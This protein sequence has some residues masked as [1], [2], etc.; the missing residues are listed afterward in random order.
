MLVELCVA[1]VLSVLINVVLFIK[2]K[3]NSVNTSA[4]NKDYENL[5]KEKNDLLEERGKLKGILE[6]KDIN[7]NQINEI[8]SKT[9]VYF[10]V[11]AI[12]KINDILIDLKLIFLKQFV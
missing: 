8:I 2:S 11:G 10:G 9:K 7:I 1:L 5:K 3:W 6:E 4:Y 12:N